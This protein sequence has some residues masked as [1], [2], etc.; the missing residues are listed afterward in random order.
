MLGWLRV[1]FNRPVTGYFSGDGQVY[2]RYYDA[3][4]NY[5]WDDNA[6]EGGS[7]LFSNERVR[8]VSFTVTDFRPAVTGGSIE[9]SSTDFNYEF[10]LH[11][12]DRPVRYSITSIRPGAV[13][14]PATWAMMIAGFGGIGGIMRLRQRAIEVR[15]V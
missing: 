11:G 2:A 12:L 3:D 10:I 6:P 1:R 5:Y 9:A 14:E 13:P 4:G 7:T 15:L 8:D